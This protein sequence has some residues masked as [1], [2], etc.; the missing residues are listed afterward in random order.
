MSLLSRLLAPVKVD[1]F[2]RHH[3]DQRSLYLPGE[4]A[5]VAALDL[6]FDLTQMKLAARELE[7][8]SGSTKAQFFNTDGVHREFL[9]RADQIDDLL[10][11]GMTICVKDVG[12]AH[13]PIARLAARLGNDLGTLGG[14]LVYAFASPPSGGFD[15]HFDTSNI[16]TFQLEGEKTWR[17]ADT[18]A[19]RFPRANHV[20]SY[21]HAE[22]EYQ[23]RHP[24]A[25]VRPPVP[26]TLETRTLRPGDL[27]F[28][29]AGTWHQTA[30]SIH[31]LSLAVNFPPVQA[32][33]V[34]AEELVRLLA[35]RRV[36]A[37]PTAPLSGWIAQSPCVRFWRSGSKQRRSPSTHCR[38]RTGGGE[39]ART[40]AWRRLPHWRRTLALP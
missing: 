10:G 35:R 27:L 18:P 32:I 13:A 3:W 2:L 1:S 8:V 14:V 16:L 21:A 12:R 33:D 40:K 20:P 7:S 22:R 34:L 9:I 30:A 11:A 6:G 5:K 37:D 15:I 17:F 19:V 24:Y 36:L 28:L 38:V 23:S 4:P 29:P 39:S 26:D 31:S 25:D